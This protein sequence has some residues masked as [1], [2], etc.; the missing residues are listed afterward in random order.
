MD[1]KTQDDWQPLH[2]AACWNNVDSAA[3]LIENG[4]DINARSKGEQTPL[5]L[6][7]LQSQ[8]SAALQLFLLNPDTDPTVINSSS[9][10]PQMIARRSG[11]YHPIFEITEPCLNDIYGT[12]TD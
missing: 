3:L 5:H 1:A 2:S 9:D 6:V 8:N 10:T 12:V 11:M 7:C 4:A